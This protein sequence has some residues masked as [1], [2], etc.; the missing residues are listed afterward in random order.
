[1]QS[2]NFRISFYYIIEHNYVLIVFY[3]LDRMRT[4]TSQQNE[5]RK[6][7]ES[8]E[9]ML[10]EQIRA[11]NLENVQSIQLLVNAVRNCIRSWERI[12]NELQ[13]RTV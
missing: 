6:Q 5:L 7:L 8:N 11:N 3:L 12:Q 10:T 13:V 1:M 2:M 4:L 9:T